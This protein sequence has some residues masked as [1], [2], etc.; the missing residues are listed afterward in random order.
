MLQILMNKAFTPASTCSLVVYILSIS[1][2]KDFYIFFQLILN[3]LH[4][5]TNYCFCDTVQKFTFA[6]LKG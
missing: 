3:V 5:P 6:N 4:T 2:I 1:I